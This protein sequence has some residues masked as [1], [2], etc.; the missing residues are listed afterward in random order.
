MHVKAL[1][2]PKAANQRFIAYSERVN[3]H[4]L[5][6]ALHEEFAKEGY[7]VATDA[8]AISNPDAKVSNAKARE[9]FGIDFIPG[10][11]SCKAMCRSVIELGL[12]KPAQ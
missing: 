12:V 2:D 7:S 5:G 9:F 6:K 11:E 4:D 1:S 8:A 10:I 3:G